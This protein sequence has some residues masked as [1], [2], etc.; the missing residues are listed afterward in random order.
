MNVSPPFPV[1]VQVRWHNCARSFVSITWRDLSHFPPEAQCKHDVLGGA[2]HFGPAGSIGKRVRQF[3]S[4]FFNGTYISRDNNRQLDY[5]RLT[6]VICYTHTRVLTWE[7]ARFE[8]PPACRAKMI[9]ILLRVIHFLLC[10][11]YL[12]EKNTTP[13]PGVGV[14]NNYL[15]TELTVGLAIPFRTAQDINIKLCETPS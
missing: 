12:S 9:Y 4:R 13:S 3:K 10:R 14:N 8:N 1:P 2:R 5:T 6:T 7:Y 11:V 15:H